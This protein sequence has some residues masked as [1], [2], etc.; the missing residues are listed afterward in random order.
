MSLVR[1]VMVVTRKPVASR[2]R[3]MAVVIMSAMV[4][5]RLRPSPRSASRMTK[6]KLMIVLSWVLLVWVAG[7]FYASP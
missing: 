3:E 6:L 7:G 1:S 2:A 4:M 5:V